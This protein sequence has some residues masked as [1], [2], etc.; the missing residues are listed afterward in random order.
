L[1][2]LTGEA[3][4]KHATLQ[5]LIVPGMGLRWALTSEDAKSS[6]LPDDCK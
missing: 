1:A 5:F 6:F 3:K 2:I 4:T